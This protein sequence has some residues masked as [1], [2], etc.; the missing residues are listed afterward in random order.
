MQHHSSP[1]LWS[2]FAEEKSA[3]ITSLVG[4]NVGVEVGQVAIIAALFPALYLLRTQGAYR[5]VFIKCGSAV[6]SMVAIFWF[7]E[8]AFAL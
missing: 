3:L 8:R 1:H 4:F 5:P 2:P 7:V 6:T